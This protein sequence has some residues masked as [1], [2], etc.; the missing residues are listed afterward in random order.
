[1]ASLRLHHLQ[2]RVKTLLYAGDWPARLAYRLGGQRQLNVDR[3]ELRLPGRDLPELRIGFASDFHAGPTTHPAR[4][5]AAC[6]A[7]RDERPDLLLF[8]GDFVSFH[9]RYVEPLATLLGSIPAPLGRYA[10]LGNH[11]RWTDEHHIARRLAAAGIELLINANRRLPPPYD[12][13]LLCGLDD[14]ETG[15]PDPARAFAGV[16]GVCLLLVHSP[17]GLRFVGD[18]RVDL[19]LCGHTHGGQVALPDGRPIL[20]PKGDLCRVYPHGRF[21]FGPERAGTLIVSRGVGYSEIPF[22]LFAPPDLLI[23]TL[24]G[25]EN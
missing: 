7:L 22:R 5:E 17:D 2:D 21:R 3:Q 24:R 15:A 9:E 14:P 25:A 8:G 6:Q 19:A 23:C 18:Q 16:A 12:Q 10:V 4:L 11:D 20:L 1:M 13:V